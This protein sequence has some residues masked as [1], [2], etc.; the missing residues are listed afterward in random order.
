MKIF[1]APLDHDQTYKK[2][3]E[4]V[5]G[6]I[7]PVNIS[8]CSG[9]AAAHLA[10]AL[11]KGASCRLVVAAG[12]DAAKGLYENLQYF[13]PDT[14]WFPSKDILFY[15][16][17][18]RSGDITRRRIN[19]LRQLSEGQR[20]TIVVSAD[21]LMERLMPEDNFRSRTLLID[22]RSV[23]DLDHLRDILRDMGYEFRSPVEVP[24][25]FGIR[26]GI[27]DIFPL[28]R[29]LPV[30]IELWGDEVDSIRE[31]NPETQRTVR[32]LDR[33]LLHPAS[34][35]VLSAGQ[36]EKGLEKIRKEYKETRAVFLKEKNREAA[37]RLRQQHEKLEDMFGT[38]YSPEQMEGLIRYFYDETVSLTAYLP[39]DT[40]VF[41][42]EAEKAVR[43]AEQHES[44]FAASMQSRLEGGYI[45]PGQADVLFSAREAFD[46]MKKFPIVTFSSMVENEDLL[47][48]A[49]SLPVRVRSVPSYNSSFERLSSDLDDWRKKG[50]AVLLL[51][52]SSTRARRLADDLRE[53]NIFTYYISDMDREIGQGEILVAAGRLS[54]GFEYPDLHLVILT[55]KDIF[56][57]RRKKAVR[58]GD[59][60]QSRKIRSISE[61]APGDYVVHDRYGLGVYRGMELIQVDGVSK[62]YINI[63]YLDNG[64]LFV[65]ATQLAVIGKYSGPGE[66][67]P[68]LNRLG[69]TEWTR[70]KSRVKSQVQIQARDLIRLYARR[71]ER[72]GFAFGKDTVWQTEFEERFPYEETEDQ[73]TA[74]ADTKRDMESNR[75]MDRLICGDVGY[76]KTEVAIRAAFKAVMDS[77]QVVFLVPTTILAQQ[78]YNSFVSRMEDYPVEIAMLSRFC[79][80]GE[81]RRIKK[82]LADGSVDIVIGTHKVLSKTIRYRNLGLL[83]I[84]EEQRFGVRQKEKIKQLKEDVDVLALSATPIPRTLHMSL[85]GIRDMSLLEIPPVDRRAIQTYV[86]EYN[87]ELIREAIER[88]LSRSGQ[89]YYVYNRVSTIPDTAARLKKLLPG[90]AVEYA[91]GKMGERQL[92]D[93]MTRFVDGEIDVLV[94]TTIIETGLDIPNVNT[95]IIENAQRFGLAQLYQLRGRVGRSGRSAYAFLLYR[96]N[97]LVREQAE[98][99]LKAIREFTDLGSGYRI[100][101]RDLEIRGAGNLLG[102]EQSGHMEAVGYELYN[103]MLK[104]AIDAMSGEKEEKEFITTADLSVDAYI[105]ESYIENETEKLY[106]YKRISNITSEEDRAD[107]IDEVTDRYGDLPSSM[108]MLMDVALLR[109]KAHEAFISSIEQKG[110]RIRFVMSDTAR[111][112][113]E[114]VDGFMKSYRGRMRLE[115]GTEPAFVW[116]AGRIGKKELLTGIEEVTAGIKE[117]LE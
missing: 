73:L 46:F 66:N 63:E 93:I 91:H 38:F 50:Y 79:T 24:G 104:E 105:P 43:A 112:R 70:T 20:M 114:E 53:N 77:K 57:A 96:R 11:G 5:A 102:A 75:I 68:K 31:F 28:T 2:I 19:I 16:A 89:V 109:S 6:G 33:I 110:D 45:L 69:G 25:E 41:V 29:D 92:E 106:W 40:M 51:S 15:S 78:H 9:A 54:E 115:P 34:E 30:R 62:D 42:E 107:M 108:L 86:M 49:L 81:E 10:D 7:S 14:V 35:L 76:G 74:I 67:P 39:E 83:I 21:V 71:R 101:M 84:D 17:D 88:E 103:R 1:T 37:K 44:A 64:N 65:P 55:E 48:P 47:K 22:S 85:S 61:I 3:K 87:E 116:D 4:A 56:K 95:I 97:E 80:A 12:E 94:S 27:V 72:E 111:V 113:V 82:G 36:A 32:N 52:S 18:L 8:G 98:K 13:D 58:K 99:R 60:Y 90:A 59:G 26:G 23:I 100:A 117:L